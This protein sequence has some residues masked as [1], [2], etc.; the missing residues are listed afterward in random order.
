MALQDMERD[1]AGCSRCSSCKWIPQN[2]VKSWRFA[3]GCPS[4]ARFNFHAYSGS[5]KMITGLSLLQGRSELNDDVA[6]IVYRCQLCGS[7]QVSCQV[8]RD[9]IDL[10][11]VLLELRARCVEDGHLLVEHMQMLESMKKED[12]PL[13]MP[14]AERGDW[15]EGLDLPDIGGSSP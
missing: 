9:D 2:Q 13:G 10:S 6:E 11:D 14:K 12:N 5:G 3:A 4:I 1:M 8:Y 15:M 7:C